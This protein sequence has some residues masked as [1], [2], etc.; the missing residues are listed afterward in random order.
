MSTNTGLLF[1]FG[2]VG[3]EV[4]EDEFNGEYWLLV[5]LYVL[6]IL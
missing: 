1:V 5:K 2:E 6:T 4:R 3:T